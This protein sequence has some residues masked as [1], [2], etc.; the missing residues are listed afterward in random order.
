MIPGERFREERRR[1]N[2]T[3]DDVAGVLR[4]WGGGRACSVSA[5]SRMENGERGCSD[6]LEGELYRALDQLDQ[7]ERPRR[8]AQ[9]LDRVKRAVDHLAAVST[10]AD[11]SSE[12]RAT[13]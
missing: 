5:L 11:A 6:E 7:E 9:A 2:R 10:E 12:R 13:G 1:R 4:A 8:V 3:L